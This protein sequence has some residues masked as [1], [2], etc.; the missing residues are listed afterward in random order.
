MY[1]STRQCF[2]RSLGTNGLRCVQQTDIFTSGAT[3][4][5]LLRSSPPIRSSK[6]PEILETRSSETTI[7]TFGT[8]GLTWCFRQFHLPRLQ[9]HLPASPDRCRPRQG[10][11]RRLLPD[12]VQ[13]RQVAPRRRG[14]YAVHQ[15]R[16][17]AEGQDDIRGNAQ[18]AWLVSVGG[19]SLAFPRLADISTMQSRSSPGSPTSKSTSPASRPRPISRARSSSAS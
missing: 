8:S 10:R 18:G 13:V 19:S 16:R 1:R 3:H 9:L 14:S 4:M 11:L 2:T 5:A 15:D 12:L 7:V 6:P 17:A